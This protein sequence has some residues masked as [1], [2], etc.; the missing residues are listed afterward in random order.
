MAH[1]KKI[2]IRGRSLKRKRHKNQS[3]YALEI[4]GRISKK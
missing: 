3:K 2:I 1:H 4:M